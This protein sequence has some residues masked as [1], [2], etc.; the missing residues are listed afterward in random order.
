MKKKPAMFLVIFGIWFLLLAHF[1]PYIL[2]YVSFQK[3]LLAKVSIFGF[4]LLLNLFW[5]Y[6]L[7]HAVIAVFAKTFK[8]RTPSVSG[9]VLY[10]KI[11]LLY[12]TSAEA[13]KHP[14]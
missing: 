5:L 13:Q 11:A 1:N 10:P 7:Y 12:L 3:N 8:V 4:V 9:P 2:R 14:R 6:G